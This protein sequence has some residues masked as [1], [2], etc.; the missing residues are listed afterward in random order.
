[1]IYDDGTLNSLDLAVE[2]QRALCIIQLNSFCEASK[3]DY[4]FKGK[5]DYSRTKITPTMT[6]GNFKSVVV[7]DRISSCS[8][9]IAQEL[10]KLASDSSDASNKQDP[11]KK[12][13]I[14]IVLDSKKDKERL[15]GLL[16]D[17]GIVAADN[18]MIEFISSSDRHLLLDQSLNDVMLLIANPIKT[19]CDYAQNVVYSQPVSHQSSPNQ[20]I[21][22]LVLFNPTEYLSKRSQ[23]ILEFND[24]IGLTK[25]LRQLKS[26]MEP[27]QIFQ[28]SIAVT[29]TQLQ[30]TKRQ[31]ISWL[32]DELHKANVCD[33]LCCV[34]TTINVEILKN[35]AKKTSNPL[36]VQIQE[37]GKLISG[38][39]R[40]DVIDLCILENAT[41]QQWKAGY[42]NQQDSADICRLVSE[43]MNQ[44]QD[45]SNQAMINVEIKEEVAILS[46]K[47]YLSEV[48]VLQLVEK[49]WQLEQELVKQVFVILHQL[50]L[51]WAVA[52]AN[53]YPSIDDY[54]KQASKSD[55]QITLE[56]YF[57]ILSRGVHFEIPVYY[58]DLLPVKFKHNQKET[59][60][61]TYEISSL[62]KGEKATI[63]TGLAW[64]GQI[65]SRSSAVAVGRL[66]VNQ[67]YLKKRSLGIYLAKKICIAS[68]S[69]QSSAPTLLQLKWQSINHVQ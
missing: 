12:K 55:R 62:I 44:L 60:M 30:V 28:L 52:V 69:S 3:S 38:L 67:E 20:S 21:S 42:A 26:I 14:K 64:N 46:C 48:E 8:Q 66:Q 59:N 17:K 22:Q 37:R 11:I 41:A 18:K 23:L 5:N 7:S 10:S 1:M 50:D 2:S 29:L 36:I 54:L 40:V 13:A 63:V 58:L 65:G 34:P 31:S 43:V 53:S 15:I 56:R 25:V 45:A 27:N 39:Y 49:R 57:E 35:A 9:I 24:P 4:D 32:F 68:S 51:F 6:L 33:M 16:A 61:L 19:S 47:G